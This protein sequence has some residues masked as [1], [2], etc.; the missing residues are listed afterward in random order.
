MYCVFNKEKTK[1]LY[2]FNMIQ[3]NTQIFVEENN[4]QN[5]FYMG[6]STFKCIFNSLYFVP[7]RYTHC[8]HIQENKKSA[9][10]V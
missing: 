2:A 6:K 8:T 5:M 9:Y 10:K 7:R 4:I 3:K 1:C